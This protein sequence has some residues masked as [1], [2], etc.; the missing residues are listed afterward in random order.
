MCSNTSYTCCFLQLLLPGEGA[1]GSVLFPFW[2]PNKDAK[3]FHYCVGGAGEF[4]RD[5][6][7]GFPCS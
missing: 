4:S 2:R 1:A 7:F 5:V 3:N 6:S